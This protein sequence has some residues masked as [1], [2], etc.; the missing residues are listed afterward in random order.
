M[1][2][3]T[4]F[5]LF[6]SLALTSCDDKLVRKEISNGDIVVR[7]YYYSYISN[8]S[9]DIVEVEKNWKREII[10]KGVDVITD[11]KIQDHQIIIDLYKPERGI[12]YEDESKSAIWDYK[13]ELNNHRN[14]DAYRYTPD[15]K[16]N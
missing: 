6:V 16:K 15:G 10:F 5:V 9:P 7:W 1:K 12:I 8:N 13:V 4:C 3:L 14:Y 2:F 11:V